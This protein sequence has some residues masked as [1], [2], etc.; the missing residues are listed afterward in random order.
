MHHLMIVERLGFRK[1][2]PNH[3]VGIIILGLLI[4]KFEKDLDIFERNVRG[5]EGLYR[6]IGIFSAREYSANDLTLECFIYCLGHESLLFYWSIV[7]DG[8]NRLSP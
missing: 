8:R 7:G 1:T 5:L 4:I 6:S 3:Q 2:A